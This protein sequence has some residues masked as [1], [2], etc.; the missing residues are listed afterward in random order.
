MIIRE[1]WERSLD[2]LLKICCV[3]T[4]EIHLMAI[5]CAAAEWGVLTSKE[6][7]KS[8]QPAYLVLSDGCIPIFDF[9]VTTILPLSHSINWSTIQTQL[10]SFMPLNTME[11]V[12]EP[13]GFS[14]GYSW[15]QSPRGVSKIPIGI[16]RFIMVFH[17][18]PCNQNNTWVDH[19][20][21]SVLLRFGRKIQTREL[22]QNDRNFCPHT[23]TTWKVNASGF[24]TWRMVGAGVLYYLKCC[25]KLTWLFRK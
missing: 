14:M 17:W 4:S 11:F 15:V 19:T 12:C 18:L 25:A 5:H 1:R 21:K 3:R 23:Y 6:K 7:R 16:P 8:L 10:G 13:C 20:E 24:A 2:Q 22:W 9:L